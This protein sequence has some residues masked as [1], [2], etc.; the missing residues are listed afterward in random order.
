MS[1][2]ATAPL[3]DGERYYR[4]GEVSRLTGLQPFVLRYWEAEIPMLCPVK[5]PSG[6]RFYRQVDVDLILKIKR[7]LY[8][9]GFTI[10]GARRHLLDLGGNGNKAMPGEPLASEPSNGDSAQLSRKMLLE[11][12]DSLR[13]FLTLLERK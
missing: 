1:S 8:E 5:S 3:P 10:A 4:I 7:L 12:R 9:E 11:L 6:R 13:S 2:P